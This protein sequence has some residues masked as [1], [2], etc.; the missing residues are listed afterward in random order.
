MGFSLIRRP[1]TGWD[2]RA[3]VI[4]KIVDYSL[5]KKDTGFSDIQA[6]FPHSGGQRVPNTLWIG[7]L[8]VPDP[9]LSVGWDFRGLGLRVG[10][11]NAPSDLGVVAL[12]P[13]SS[14]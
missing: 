13:A 7:L 10:C 6:C 5:W 14:I 2:F 4:K 9:T 12:C 11:S 3:F 1:R 8:K